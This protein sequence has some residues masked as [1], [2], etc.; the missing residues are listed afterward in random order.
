MRSPFTR[1]ASTAALALCVLLGAAASAD[2]ATTPAQDFAVANER[3]LAGDLAG[4]LQLYT[5]VHARAPRD[6]DVLLNLGNTY[7]KLGRTVD[8]IVAYE[9]GLA[10]APDDAD[11]RDNLARLRALRARTPEGPIVERLPEA[12]APLS[13]A[14]GGEALGLALLVLTWLV[15]I[16]VGV[17]LVLGPARRGRWL[18]V[19]GVFAVLLA[20]VAALFA[21]DRAV[22]ADPIAIAAKDLGLHDGPD[23]RMRRVLAIVGGERLV[24]REAQGAWLQVQT[25]DGVVGWVAE[26]DVVRR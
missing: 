5:S 4:A 13:G 15:A 6:A 9:R 8:A 25:I 1:R 10:L 26:R 23:A 12:L 20:I 22:R 7:A 11:L 3:Y 18:R 21:A 17:G 16:G 19:S 14:I 24:V 2:D